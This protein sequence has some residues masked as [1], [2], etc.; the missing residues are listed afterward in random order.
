MSL[1][2]DPNQKDMDLLTD[3]IY[4]TGKLSSRA[5]SRGTARGS[6][7]GSARPFQYTDKKVN[8]ADEV[9]TSGAGASPD[10]SSKLRTDAV[11]PRE[12]DDSAADHVFNSD[13][14]PASPRGRAEKQ[15]S[16]RGRSI[17]P[18][19]KAYGKR[20]DDIAVWRP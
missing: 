10:T 20:A 8:K 19:D 6:P 17:S 15:H 16:P 9:E 1:Q 14:K 3:M 13:S 4:S 2:Y 11:K 12:L 7:M 5:S 18:R